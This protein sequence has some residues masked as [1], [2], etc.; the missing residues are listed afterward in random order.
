M[1]G[2]KLLIIVTLLIMRGRRAKGGTASTCKDDILYSVFGSLA[3]YSLLVILIFILYNFRKKRKKNSK[4]K[5]QKKKSVEGERNHVYD[6]DIDDI[7][8]DRRRQDSGFIASS[9]ESI[10]PFPEVCVETPKRSPSMPN[11]STRCNQN[12][13]EV[14]SDTENDEPQLKAHMKSTGVSVHQQKNMATVATSTDDLIPDD[15]SDSYMRTEF[16]TVVIEKKSVHCTGL[17]F[18]IAG[19]FI[20]DFD[21]KEIAFKRGSLDAGDEVLS[22]NDYPLTGLSDMEAFSFF[23]KSGPDVKLRIIKSRF[24]SK[25]ESS[26]IISDSSLN[27]D[28]KPDN[29]NHTQN[30][31]GRLPRVISDANNLS[32]DLTNAAQQSQARNM[33]CDI[34]YMPIN[35]VPSN[36]GDHT[37]GNVM[38]HSKH[39]STDENCNQTFLNGYQ[40]HSRN[41][42][43]DK[44][45]H[46]WNSSFEQGLISRTSSSENIRHSRHSSNENNRHNSHSSDENNRN[47]YH[48]SDELERN[49]YT[50]RLLN[51]D[52]VRCMQ[53]SLAP[54]QRQSLKDASSVSI[55]TVESFARRSDGQQTEK[56]AQLYYQDQLL[57]QQALSIDQTSYSDNASSGLTDQYLQGT[58]ALL[59]ENVVL[60]R[61]YNNDYIVPANYRMVPSCKSLYATRTREASPS[62]RTSSQVLIPSPKNISPL[63]IT[64]ANAH[65]H[66]TVTSMSS[67]SPVSPMSISS[68]SI[69][70]RY[71][72]GQDAYRMV[73][74]EYNNIQIRADHHET[75][76]PTSKSYSEKIDADVMRYM[77]KKYSEP[78]FVNGHRKNPPPYSSTHTTVDTPPTAYGLTESDDSKNVI[79]RRSATSV[80]NGLRSRPH[81]LI[82]NGVSS[83]FELHNE[84]KNINVNEKRKYPQ[85]THSLPA[86]KH[87]EMRPRTA[88][89]FLEQQ[90]RVPKKQTP[91]KLRQIYSQ[92]NINRRKSIDSG[93]L[94]KLAE[95][96]QVNPALG[97]EYPFIAQLLGESQFSASERRAQGLYRHKS[98]EALSSQ[99]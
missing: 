10:V 82:E 89:S 51:N 1:L 71:N 18:G 86:V 95:E 92:E 64:T 77:T 97:G 50:S 35:G 40:S 2:K 99:F 83:G 17:D 33:C 19:I 72:G 78:R 8:G 49:L 7:R 20:K 38:T 74:S 66:A 36:L 90:Q 60:K 47:S 84:H 54:H 45:R 24:L 87:L 58:S 85:R 39:A 46:S 29:T 28:V 5:R 68:L 22:I 37:L 70:S 93:T 30:D 41:S 52:T 55:F 61:G 14:N 42:S 57:R 48:S 96:I 81:S 62:K 80:S 15:A 12:N 13:T 23:A 79:L 25:V 21:E 91:K 98:T 3:A 65:R 73:P 88:K 44:T 9:N 59:T 53:P 76:S 67:G 75:D 16:E 27:S 26:S 43:N 34:N 94:R 6:E 69:G 31:F 32:I 56:D 4:D 11:L 63:A